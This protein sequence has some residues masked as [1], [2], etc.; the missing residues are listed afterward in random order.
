MKKILSLVGLFL[1]CI[2]PIAVNAETLEI[3]R[4]KMR[5]SGEDAN[6]YITCTIVYVITGDEGYDNLTVTLTEKGG[7]TVTN[8]SNAANSDWTVVD[9]SEDPSTNV[10]TVKLTSPGVT[11]E[12]DL[13]KLTYKA[14]GT[15]DCEIEVG[16]GD[17]HVSI[18][19]DEPDKPEEN[20][21]TGAALPFIAL[22]SI[23][24]VAVGAY[25]A[26]KNKTK[27]YKI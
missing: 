16:I 14:S 19:P 23:A 18:T 25:L 4:E 11:G 27:M 6:G 12:G 24:L 9:Q 5:C 1:I 20:K 13:F 26:T 22:G 10:W 7:A 2:L 8:I 15:K 21:D 17:R 3:P